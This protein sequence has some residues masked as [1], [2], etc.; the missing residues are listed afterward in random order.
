MDFNGHHTKLNP[1][2]LNFTKPKD[3]QGIEESADIL[4][5]VLKHIGAL[6]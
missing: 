3:D 4:A 6:S 1:A 2:C 5:A